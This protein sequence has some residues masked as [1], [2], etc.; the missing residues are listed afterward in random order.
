VGEIF[1]VEFDFKGK[2]WENAA[3]GLQAFAKDLNSSFDRASE[4]L[5][6]EVRGYL[7]SVAVA[8]RKRHSQPW[9]GGTTDK[10]LSMRSGALV[11]DIE[12]SV[13]VT[14]DRIGNIEGTIGS[15]LPYARIQEYGGTIYPK[16]AKFLAIPLTAALDSRGVPLR[17]GPRF[18]QNTFVAKSKAGNLLIFQ[19]R[20]KDIIP[21]Y[22]L[23]DKVTIPARLGLGATIRSQIPYFQERA[24]NKMLASIRQSI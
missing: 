12:K 23:K 6:G 20:G 9:P 10:T 13:A 21:L 7:A 4:V 17:Q 14:G 16:H 11:A 18:W 24:M 5:S 8:I 1:K 22:V 19:R 15:T 2:R 3:Q